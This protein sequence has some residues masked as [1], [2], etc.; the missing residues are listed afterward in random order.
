[1]SWGWRLPFLASF[2]LVGLGL[3]VRLTL[4]ETPEFKA[5]LAEAAPA[6]V[7][8]GEV[9]SKHWLHVLG[10]TFGVVACFCLYYLA[11]AFALGYGVGTL[12]YTRESF[13]GIQLL[14]ILFMAIGTIWAATWSDFSS[15]RKVLMWGCGLVVAASFLLA[16]LMG[17]GSLWLIAAFLCLALLIMG[18]VYGPLGAWLTSLYPARVRYTG[19]SIAFNVGGVIGGGMTPLIAEQ[20]VSTGGL[21]YVGYYL[22]FAGVLSFLALLLLRPRAEPASAVTSAV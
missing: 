1:M 21:H 19:V 10:G 11:T 14:S 4:A 9:L 20:L 7:P 18:F 12:G 16:P 3:W 5:A 8:F 2:V 13:L 6:H 15:P 22:A 17:A